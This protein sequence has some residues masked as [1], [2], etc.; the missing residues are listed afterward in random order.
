MA[1]LFSPS[2]IKSI[3]RLLPEKSLGKFRDAMRKFLKDETGSGLAPKISASVRSGIQ[4]QITQV[5][6]QIKRFRE[7]HPA[8]DHVLEKGLGD[9]DWVQDLRDLAKSGDPTAKGLLPEVDRALG[10]ME[11]RLAGL[12]RKLAELDGP[13]GPWD[14]D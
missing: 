2:T 5:R 10:A 1:L 14:I 12:E 9:K 8:Q 7:S 11:R 6:E 13:K 4:K 3:A